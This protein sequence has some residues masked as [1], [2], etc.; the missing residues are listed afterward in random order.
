[1]KVGS[2]VFVHGKADIKDRQ[3]EVNSGLPELDKINIP[4]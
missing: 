2:V 4:A 1:M 3:S